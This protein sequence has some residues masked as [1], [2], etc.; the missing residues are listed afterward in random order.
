MMRCHCPLD[1][2]FMSLLPTDNTLTAQSQFNYNQGHPQPMN[3]AY[4]K[5]LD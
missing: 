4:P 2:N 5:F 1:L 3:P